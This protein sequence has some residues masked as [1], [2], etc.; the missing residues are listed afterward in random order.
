MKLPQSATSQQMT[1]QTAKGGVIGLIAYALMKWNFD[2]AFIA[3]VLPL[4]AAIL[5]WVSTRI[6][7]TQI[8]SFIGTVGIDDGKP[9]KVAAKSAVKKAPAKKVAKK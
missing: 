4:A 6:G 8:A 9:V 7:D 1:D 2:P 3:L 5:S